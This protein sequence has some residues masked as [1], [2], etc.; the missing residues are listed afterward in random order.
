[1]IFDRYD[2]IAFVLIIAATVIPVVI[3]DLGMVASVLWGALCGMYR[4]DI[5]RCLRHIFG[6]Y[7]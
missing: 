6:I 4:Y 3:L 5:S 2:W 7:R 1:M